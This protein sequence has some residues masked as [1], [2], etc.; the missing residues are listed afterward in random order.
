M[1]STERSS[2]T[3][4]LRRPQI[5][6]NKLWHDGVFNPRKGKGSSTL[7]ILLLLFLAAM[8]FSA[9]VT[10]HGSEGDCGFSTVQPKAMSHF[11]ER[12][13]IRKVTPDYPPATKA[14]RVTGTV[15]VR[16]LINRKGLVE[17]TCPEFV[18][19][20]PRPDRTLVIAAEAAA[21]QWTFDR[22]FGINPPNGIT[23]EFAE[24]VLIF[25]FTLD[26]LRSGQD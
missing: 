24:D 26:G 22:D 19:G 11:V 13:T 9:Q 4:R 7:R 14:K 3:E 6:R 17:R 20:Q 21:L 1:Y 8:P 25:N 2:L 23:F 16:V 12:G 10:E 15:R 5:K 18:K